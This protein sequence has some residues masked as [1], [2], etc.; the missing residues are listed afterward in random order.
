VAAEYAGN[1]KRTL[2]RDIDQIADLARSALSLIFGIGPILKMLVSR[3]L[4]L[5]S[6]K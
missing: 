1:G 4:K 5:C 2:L 6:T 3:V